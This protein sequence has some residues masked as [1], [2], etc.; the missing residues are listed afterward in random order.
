MSKNIV[1][2]MFW[3]RD[4]EEQLYEY[5]VKF[6][7][8]A[9]LLNRLI[10]E[11]YLGKKINFLNIYFNTQ[12]TY[13]H[14]EKLELNYTHSG[15]GNI[16]HN[17]IFLREEFDPKPIAEQKRLLWDLALGVMI[18]IA[19]DTEN[20]DLKTCSETAYKKGIEQS[21][22]EDFILLRESNKIEE[23]ELKA[24]LWAEF[25]ENKVSA[26]FKIFNNEE[27]IFN[28]VIDS[29][30]PDVEFFYEMYKKIIFDPKG[31]II[32]KGHY[33]VEYLPLIVEVSELIKKT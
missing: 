33:E 17:S 1:R 8:L 13:D 3:F 30:R 22:R 7:S 23:N 28:K 10:S 24:E 5:T 2:L 19:D 16:Q 31:K 26:R 11:N 29:T 27:L 25:E 12:S 20:F 18:K 14:Y 21:L 9:M 4:G 32:I 15:G 6:G